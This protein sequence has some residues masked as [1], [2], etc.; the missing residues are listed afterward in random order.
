MPQHA[1]P[2]PREPGQ[3]KWLQ[4]H[5]KTLDYMREKTEQQVIEAES[6]VEEA[7]RRFSYFGGADSAALLAKAQRFLEHRGRFCLP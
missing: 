3:R 4:N 7:N 6:A 2:G 5:R 1:R